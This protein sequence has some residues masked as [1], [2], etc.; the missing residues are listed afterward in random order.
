MKTGRT[1]LAVVYVHPDGPLDAA[2]FDQLRERVQERC[3]ALLGPLL[4]C[5]VIPT[6]QA[7][8]VPDEDDG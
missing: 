1:Y 2:A 4:F 3:Q 6:A 7:P 8:F 5:E